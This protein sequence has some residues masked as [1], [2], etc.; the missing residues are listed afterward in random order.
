MLDQ[1][2]F[3]KHLPTFFPSLLDELAKHGFVATLVGG[4]VRDFFHLGEPGRD[5]DI[6]LSHDSLSFEKGAW[7]DLG[8][9]LARFGKT[10]YL[11][12]EVL[13]VQADEWQLEFSPPRI[14]H[15]RENAKDHSNFDAEFDFKLPFEEA[16]KRR[17][18]TIN[19]I[20]IRF[21]SKKE[22]LFLDP[23]EGLRHLREKVLH[24]AGPDF[25]KDPVRFLRAHRFANR[26]KFA[27]S[28]ELRLVLETM[29]LEG[30]TPAY[31]W[32]E[33]QKASDPVNFL[34]FLVQEKNQ[35]LKV[36]LEK[37]FTQKVPE[38]KKVLNDPRKHETWIV[39]LEWVDISS[40][41]WAAYFSFSSE[42]S[43]RLGRWAKLSKNFQQVLP[44]I[45]H[46][47]FESV[48]DNEEFEKLFDWYFT[49]KQLLQKYPDLPLMKMIE[50][51]LPHWIH[52]YKFEAVKDVKHID[53]PYRAKYQVW[54]I[55]QRL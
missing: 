9:A 48:R 52:L 17:D 16:V 18:F 5:W 33:M 23:L 1:K 15:Y 50:D 41:A 53:P 29:H 24:F 6:E 20:G 46:G 32:S 7:K 51:Y 4:A 38:V 34:S 2:K 25:G 54:N 8:R 39:A 14:E 13:R 40:D 37:S 47:E 42:T 21:K 55:C 28:P 12:Y 26:L 11:P 31:L 30:I 44:E 19:A 43:K 49:T 27:F 3:E 10:S 45:F 22:F 35:E 36:P